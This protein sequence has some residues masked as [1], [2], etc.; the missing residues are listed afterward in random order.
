MCMIMLLE[1]YRKHCYGNKI[2][3]SIRIAIKKRLNIFFFQLSAINL[4]CLPMNHHTQVTGLFIHSSNYRIF[5]EW[6]DSWNWIEFIDFLV[7]YYRLYQPH[8]R[9]FLVCFCIAKFYYN[10]SNDFPLSFS[11]SFNRYKS[12]HVFNTK[13]LHTQNSIRQWMVR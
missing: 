4:K 2:Q 10:I 5:D 13:L 7:Y 8:S 3:C 1:M 6:D 12:N 11:F 9:N